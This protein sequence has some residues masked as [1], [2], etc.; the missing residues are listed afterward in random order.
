MVTGSLMTSAALLFFSV[1]PLV[2]VNRA[3][4]LIFIDGDFSSLLSKLVDGFPPKLTGPLAA[5][6]DEGETF[7]S[8]NLTRL[9]S[10]NGARS[11]KLLGDVD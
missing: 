2:R 11:P 8:D 4:R 1:C 6:A 9:L 7:R 10:A 5:R 3:G